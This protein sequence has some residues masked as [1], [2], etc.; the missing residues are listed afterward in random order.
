MECYFKNF[1]YGLRNA[2]TGEF[3]VLARKEDTSYLTKHLRAYGGTGEHEG[4]TIGRVLR[5]ITFSGKGFVDKPANSDSIIFSRTMIDKFLEEK[6]T[7]LK[8]R[9]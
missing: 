1:D 4:Y 3:K 6:N 2:A 9:V 8:K 5:D 7:I